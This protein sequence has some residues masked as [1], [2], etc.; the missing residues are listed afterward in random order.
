MK[1][2]VTSPDFKFGSRIHTSKEIK[3]KY[4]QQHHSYFKATLLHFII[5]CIKIKYIIQYIKSIENVNNI[6]GI[7]R[8]KNKHTPNT[9]VL[10]LLQTKHKNFTKK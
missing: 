1:K 9:Y 10:H 5:N 2:I 6:A 3:K 8:Q 7:R 4:C